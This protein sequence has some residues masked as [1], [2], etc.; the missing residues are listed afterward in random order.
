MPLKQG[1]SQAT[2]SSNISELMHSFKQGGRFARGKSS[3]KARQ[4][5]IAAAFSMKRQ[6]K[7]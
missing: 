6:S 4:I 7:K 5:A 2:V 3:G 1:K